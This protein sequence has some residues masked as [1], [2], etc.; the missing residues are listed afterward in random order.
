[1]K[2]LLIISYLVY[3][4]L[5]QG[6]TIGFGLYLVFFMG[7]NPWWLVLFVI[8]STACYSPR[9]WRELIDPIDY[10]NDDDDET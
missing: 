3:L 9:S 7:R 6:M 5:W 8:L 2:T 4:L 1:M 10:L